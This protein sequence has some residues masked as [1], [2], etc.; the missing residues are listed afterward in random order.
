MLP[1]PEAHEAG[2]PLDVRLLG[3]DA[4][5]PEPDALAHPGEQLVDVAGSGW[6]APRA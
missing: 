6:H 1:A 4:V 3:A 5:V 2:D